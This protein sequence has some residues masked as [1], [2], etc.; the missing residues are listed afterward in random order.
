MLT[1]SHGKKQPNKSHFLIFLGYKIFLYAYRDVYC[2]NII[3]SILAREFG[4]IVAIINTS[5]P[6]FIYNNN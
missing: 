5:Y 6:Y 3:I 1:Y 4:M 2:A